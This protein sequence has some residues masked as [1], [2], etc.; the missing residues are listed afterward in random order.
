MDD[1]RSPLTRNKPAGTQDNIN[2]APAEA[3]AHL[4]A[5][6]AAGRWVPAFAGTAG[7]AWFHPGRVGQTGRGRTRNHTPGASRA[8]ATRRRTAE[9]VRDRIR[10]CEAAEKTIPIIGKSLPGERGHNIRPSGIALWRVG[11]W[12]SQAGR[13]PRL[14]SRHQK[15]PKV[16]FK[17]SERR[18]ST[19]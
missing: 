7:C 9:L 14:T 15:P 4:S 18:S 6:R 8:S 1:H 13:T 16:P 2:A 19:G 5:A 3:G 17:V 11:R 12:L 10:V